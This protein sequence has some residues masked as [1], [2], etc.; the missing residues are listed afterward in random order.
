MNGNRPTLCQNDP[1]IKPFHFVCLCGGGEGG[2][3][4]GMGRNSAF[5]DAKIA[6][7]IR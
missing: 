4:G 7:D 5:Q 3:G 2:R 1:C 6:Q